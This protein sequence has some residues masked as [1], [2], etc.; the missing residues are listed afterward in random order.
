M[1]NAKTVDVYIYSSRHSAESVGP[2]SA[3][4]LVH[5]RPARLRFDEPSSPTSGLMGAGLVRRSRDL[6]SASAAVT[7]RRSLSGGGLPNPAVEAL[8]R[9]RHQADLAVRGAVLPGLDVPPGDSVVHLGERVARLT[10]GEVE[11]RRD[12]E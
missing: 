11:L 12:L 2:A 6:D 1:G 7:L 4:P 3:I 9:C 8:E 10:I 5:S